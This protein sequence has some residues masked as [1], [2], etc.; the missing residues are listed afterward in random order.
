MVN[1][2][3]DE[4]LIGVNIIVKETSLGAATDKNGYFTILNIRGGKYTLTTSMI[5]FKTVEIKNITVLADHTSTVDIQMDPAAVEGEEVI[6]TAKRPVIVRD[7]TATTNIFLAEDIENMPVNSY[8]DVLNN[9]AGVV[10]SFNSGS[11][12]NGLHIRGGR[13]NE[14]AYMV[15]GF[16][17]EDAIYG[18]MGTDVSKAGISELSVI[19]GAFNAEYGEAMSGV[20]NILTKE[21]G[22]N[23]NASFRLS[24]DQLGF[25]EDNNRSIY[26]WNTQRIEGSLGG[27]VPL[28]FLPKGFAAFFIAG[29]LHSTDTFLGRTEAVKPMFFDENDN[30]LFDIDEEYV[31]DIYDLDNDGNTTEP[32]KKNH[33][34]VNSTYEKQSRLNAKLTL[35][36]FSGIKLTFGGIFN[37]KKNRNFPGFSMSYKLLQDNIAPVWEN[38]DLFYVNLN[39]TLSSKTF[40]NIKVSRFDNRSWEG[41]EKYMNN[42][43]EMTYSDDTNQINTYWKSYE[44]YADLNGDGNYSEG[45]PFHDEDGDG[46]WDSN[47]YDTGMDGIFAESFTDTDGNSTW[48]SGEEF[49]DT[50]G[51]GIWNGPDEGELDGMPTT[52]EDGVIDMW[53]SFHAEP[54]NDSPDGI[55]R[56]GSADI[57]LD[58]NGDGV[59]NPEDGDYLIDLAGDGVWQPGEEFVD[60]D[61]NGVYNYGVTPPYRTS[62]F[63]GESNYEFYGGHAIY[64]LNGDSVRWAESEDNF[65]ER[66]ASTST[67]I[68]ANLTSQVTQQHQIKIGGGLKQLEL[69]DFQIRYFGGGIYGIASD[70]TFV[71]WK[72]EPSQR[73]FY[74]QDK[75][76]FRDWVINL[77]L[78]YDYLDPNSEYADPKRKLAYIDQ[79]GNFSE[80]NGTAEPYFDA[81]NGVWDEGEFFI[82][83]NDNNQYDAGEIFTDT[84]NGLWDWTDTPN[85]SWDPS[86]SFVDANGNG[87]YDSTET[88]AD[89]ANGYFDF[90]DDYELFTDEN[91]DGIWT[92][93]VHEYGYLDDNGNF[94]SPPKATIKWKLSP[95]IGFGYP[96]TDRIAFHFSYG[97]FYQYPE[98]EKMFRFANLGNPS[99][100]GN[101]LYPFPYSLSDF[102][103]PSVGNPNLKPETTI[104]YEFGLRWQI[105]DNFLLKTTVFYKD[106]YDYISAVIYYTDP[107]DYAIFENLDYGN[108]RGIELNLKKLFRHNYSFSITYVYSKSVA[109][110][111]NEYTHWNEA[112]LASVYGTYPSLKTITMPWDQPHTMNFAVDYRNPKGYGLNIVGNMG[113]GLPYTP[114]DSRGQNLS[115]SN[116]G[117]M[118][119]TAAVDMKIY[120]DFS[121]KPFTVR[122]FSDITNMEYLLL[123]KRNVRDVFST[124]GQPDDSLNPNS[125]P[126]WE[127]RPHYFGPP[128]HIELGLNLIFN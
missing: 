70:P 38:S 91:E 71:Q 30:Q 69:E 12:D 43:R 93:A 59:Y 110:A 103:I 36:P 8:V 16:F 104:A 67:T 49:V 117:R 99:I 46:V 87:M 17:V 40:Y 78:R 55:Y 64:D 121:F 62:A 22:Q 19:T 77:G 89:V 86:E 1:S 125:S 85:G 23:F 54:F 21:G 109:N 5:G 60:L 24:T 73:S 10:E 106:I 76:E 113:S 15:D 114:T 50:N 48:S 105:S 26:D 124:T 94:V 88:W 68:E 25:Y 63:N 4:P 92:D 98:Y 57:L 120:K 126:A 122:L 79:F 53:W 61:G 33:V 45:E 97:Q 74:I 34:Y 56:E 80:A 116:S 118:S 47:V 29:D 20:V 128:T 72:Y 37:R 13:S 52:G 51:D 27:P 65:Y 81:G 42:D 111:A 96:I 112:Y 115:E 127:D 82:D 6:I 108:S 83:E 107:T 100:Y 44:P 84:G 2:E 123:S 7:E 39:H 102:Y 58:A 95:R 14:I 9:V 75:I 31:S 35:H 28:L 32:L 11:Q 66:Y 41:L 18:G 3:N 119:F 90:E 101:S